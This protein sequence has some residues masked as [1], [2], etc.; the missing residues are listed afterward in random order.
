[1]LKKI[2]MILGFCLVLSGCTTPNVKLDKQFWDKQHQK[3][4]IAENTHPIPTLVQT[5]CEGG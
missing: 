5:G 1:M 2:V 4:A 3:I